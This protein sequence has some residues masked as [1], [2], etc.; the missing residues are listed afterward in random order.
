[1]EIIINI[2]IKIAIHQSVSHIIAEWSIF[3]LIACLIYLLLDGLQANFFQISNISH[4]KYQNLNGSYL[5]LQLALYNP[6]KPGVKWRMK[7]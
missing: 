5:V 6:L 2:F 3:N 4:T 1:M 7:M